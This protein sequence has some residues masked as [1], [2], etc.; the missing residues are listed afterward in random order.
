MKSTG[1]IKRID[2]LGRIVIPKEIRRNLGIR[3]G[4]SLEI[5]VEEDK[6]YLKKYSKLKDYSL[7]I[8][9]ILECFDKV[10]HYN[11]IIT[12]RD[13]I[14]NSNIDSSL[15]GLPLDKKLLSFIKNRESIFK[16][17]MQTYKFL[18]KELNG[19]FF[20]NPVI[21]SVDCLGLVAIYSDMPI[22]IEAVN[23]LKLIVSLIVQNID[24]S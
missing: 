18:D 19:Y 1:V 10:Y 9:D 5:Y 11:F 3:D 2:E 21:T 13:K 6:I 15:V 4:E 17:E 7:I 8:K 23:V 14:I 20:I 16:N 22:N 24:I 12:D